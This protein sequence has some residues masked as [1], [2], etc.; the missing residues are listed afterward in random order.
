M[1]RDD[2]QLARL[3]WGNSDRSRATLGHVFDWIA[4]EGVR[5]GIGENGEQRNRGYRPRLGPF[6]PP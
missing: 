6:I 5:L 3:C 2:E 1:W 4:E